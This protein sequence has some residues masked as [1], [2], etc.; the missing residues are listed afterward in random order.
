R[1]RGL[2]Q[3]LVK[4]NKRTKKILVVDDEHDINLALKFV[5]DGGFN[6]DSSTNPLT[7]LQN[8]KTDLYDMEV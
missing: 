5:L 6:V 2:K 1:E 3:Q 7:A 8:F 4:D